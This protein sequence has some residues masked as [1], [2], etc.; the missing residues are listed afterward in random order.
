MVDCRALISW[1]DM[2]V[3]LAA[4]TRT[5]VGDWERSFVVLGHRVPL[6]RR[7]WSS[8]GGERCEG[9][10]KGETFIEVMLPLAHDGFRVGVIV[11]VAHRHI[12]RARPLGWR[13]QPGVQ[14]L[15]VG[16]QQG[17]RFGVIRPLHPGDG[18]HS[19]SW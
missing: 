8:N 11:S 4:S 17:P 7:Q 15:M 2:E 18:E 9:W 12:Y 19:V 16:L 1:A 3:S 10:S 6:A 5:P 14:E 13:M